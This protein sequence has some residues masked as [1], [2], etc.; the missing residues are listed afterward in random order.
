MTRHLYLIPISGILFGLLSIAPIAPILAGAGHSHGNEFQD[1]G[2]ANV[3][4]TRVTVDEKTARELQI[5]TE[6]VQRR[7]LAAGIKTTGQLEALPNRQVEITNPVSGKIV[8]ILVKPGDTLIEGQP[9]AILNSPELVELQVSAGEQRATARA[10]LDKARADLQLARENDERVRGI[11]RSASLTGNEIASADPSLFRSNSILAVA[12]ENYDRQKQISGAEIDSATIELSVAKEQYERDRELAERGAIPKRQMRESQAKYATAEAKL[13]R[14]E[15]RPDLLEAE[16]ALKQAE[17]DFRKELASARG[18][19][20]RA[21]AAVRAAEE[22][23]RLSDTIYK[24]RLAQLQTNA[25]SGGRV[26][27]RSPISGRVADREVTLGQSFQ[28]AGEKLMTVVNDDRVFA[29]ANIYEKDLARVKIG[30]S[31]R[32]KVNGFP[33]RTFRGTIGTI[34]SGVRGDSR[35]VPVRAEIQ[36]PRDELKPGM[37]ADLEILTGDNARQA[38]AIPATAIVEANTRNL[39]YVKN[40]NTYQAIEVT[41]G[42]T[43]GD[44]V[45]I[46]SGLFTGDEVV[47]RRAPQLY[48]QALKGSGEENRGDE[49]KAE[50]PGE[51]API[52]SS[53]L[54]IWWLPV[55]G[56][57]AVGMFWLGSVYGDRRRKM[58]RAGREIPEKPLAES[59]ENPEKRS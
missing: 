43:V 20:K 49:P 6:T 25:D 33:E 24:T 29:V 57:L 38:I 26:T 35:V 21:G 12:K 10:E 50:P 55:G 48:A 41:L 59:L 47:T 23:L 30:Q 17:L 52:A 13:I 1:G 5:R 15:S 32:V 9:V 4:T 39:V 37:F 53:P 31:V 28:D 11:F 3:E 7:R 58:A 56:V 27:I 2:G 44:L 14:A 19:V 40:G 22:K 46:R 18:E 42:E 8:E 45:E 36:N 51:N 16:S 54:S 34:G